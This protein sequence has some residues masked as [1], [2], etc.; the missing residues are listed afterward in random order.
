MIFLS[1]VCLYLLYTGFLG[2]LEPRAQTPAKPA[3]AVVYSLLVPGL[4]HK[5][6]HDGRWNRSA[7]LYTVVDVALM[8]G[9]ISS[10]WQRRYLVNSY[11][12]W[13]SSYAG[14]STEGKDRSF[15]LTIG[16]H[17]SSD[18]Y[19]DAQLRERRVDLANRVNDPEF[20]WSW[21][22]IEDLQRYRDL[23]GSSESWSQRRGSLI[24]ALVANRL[25]AAVTSLIA[26]RRQQ[27]QV[28]E[29]AVTPDSM[30]RIALTL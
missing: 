2:S 20:Q 13:A 9:L 4:G 16:N 30:I 22:S 5:Y 29:V 1:V 23:R 17:L 14:I 3:K 15:Y 19:R 26:A 25:I 7:T 6:I 27:D 11:Q 10:E 8:V 21:N 18:A 24:V 12:T 28:L